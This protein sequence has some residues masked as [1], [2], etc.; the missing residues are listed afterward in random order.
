VDTVIATADVVNAFNAQ[1]IPW[2][3]NMFLSFAPSTRKAKGRLTFQ[4]E[5]IL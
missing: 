2:F 3:V 4:L 1:F 5:L